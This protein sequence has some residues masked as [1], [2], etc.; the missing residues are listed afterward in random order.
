MSSSGPSLVCN[1]ELL[2]SFDPQVKF[3]FFGFFKV[4][5]AFLSI[6][7]WGRLK[8]KCCGGTQLVLDLPGPGADGLSIEVSQ[9]RG[10]DN[11]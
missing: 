2:K 6:L 3:K 7:L 10:K 8:G 9:R 11:I 1:P 4:R 5:F